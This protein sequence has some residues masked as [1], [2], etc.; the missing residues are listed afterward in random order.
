M[1]NLM[2]SYLEDP[3]LATLYQRVREAGPI[4]SISVDLTHVCN[5]RCQGCYYFAEGMDKGMSDPSDEAFDHFVESELER[6]TNFVTVVGGEPS[7]QLDR[8]KILYDNFRVNVATNGLVKIPFEGFENMPFGIAVWGD[9]ETDRF[10]R[11]GNRHNVFQTALD[12]YKDDPRAFW[13]Y[14]ITPGNVH[15]I[16]TVVARC[17]ENGNPVLFNFYSDLAGLGPDYGGGR[18][19]DE[20]LE[21]IDTVIERYPDKILLSRYLARTIADG[22]LYGQRWGHEVCTSLTADHPANLERLDN[23]NPYNPHFK[24]YQSNLE[25]TRRCCTG[26]DRNCDTC[27]DV[28]EHYSWVMLNLRKHLGS[29]EEFTHWLTSMYMF[30]MINRLVDFEEGIRWL[31]EIHERVGEQVDSLLMV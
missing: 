18:G 9:H 4:R 23:G 15:E 29:R 12:N 30:Y 25:D 27:F 5:L 22:E 26:I 14:T 11:G 28:W 19:F 2:R 3:F 20:A 24:A 7:L 1:R 6:G 13:Y 31:P 10:L 21:A 8:L 16:E 17:V